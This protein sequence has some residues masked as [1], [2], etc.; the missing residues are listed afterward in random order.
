M[1]TL[2][3]VANKAGVSP[4]TVSRVLN[5]TGRVSDKVRTQVKKV[6][7][8]MGYQPN[9]NARALA[10]SKSEVFGL[11]I[12]NISTPFN[13]HLSSGISE[14]IH[15]CNYKLLV[16]NSY[17][18]KENE[19][20]AIQ[21]FRAQGCQNIL[22]HTHVLSD[23]ELIGLAN[24]IKGLVIINRLV[25]KISNRCIWLDNVLGG[26]MAAQHCLDNGHE[27]I[28]TLMHK[29]GSNDDTSRLAG[30]ESTL[31][32]AGI[33]LDNDAIL[34]GEGGEAL[35]RRLAV[36]LIK[37]DIEFTAV[38]AYND[39]IAIGAL[40]EF[41]DQGIKVPEDVSIVGFDDM[42]ICTMTRPQL[43]TIHHPIAEMAKYAAELSIEL[44]SLKND[45]HNK[46]HMFI[47]TLIERQSVYKLNAKY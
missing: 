43:T 20:N 18:I 40:N 5:G 39:L 6:I 8:E 35:G 45:L 44:T 31:N 36:E 37:S 16:T 32:N 30:I 28:V 22:I 29:H 3:D 13:G 14:L 47:P 38:I 41:Q 33:A 25:Q 10:S 9:S 42:Y 26:Q 1:I 27:K 2:N 23:E 7:K 34:Y 11:V 4:S 12:S 21:S 19:L 17:D 24:E 15:K 46:T